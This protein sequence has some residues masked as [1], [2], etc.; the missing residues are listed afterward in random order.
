MFS[1]RP[2]RRKYRL[3]PIPYS[4]WTLN[5]ERRRK[6]G[7]HSEEI[8]YYTARVQNPHQWEDKEENQGNP[9][10]ESL[11]RNNLLHSEGTGPTPVGRQ[12]RKTINK[13][14][15]RKEGGEKTTTQRNEKAPPPEEMKI[16][17]SVQIAR[18]VTARQSSPPQPRK[19]QKESRRPKT[20]EKSSEVRRIPEVRRLQSGPRTRSPETSQSPGAKQ[21]RAKQ[22]TSQAIHKPSRPRAKQPPETHTASR[23]TQPVR[24]RKGVVVLTEPPHLPDKRQ[25]R[26][27]QNVGSGQETPRRRKRE[28]SVKLVRHDKDTFKKNSKEKGINKDKDNFKRRIQGKGHDKDTFTTPKRKESTR[29]R[30]T[31]KE[32][33]K[34]KDN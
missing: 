8:N 27:D 30:I 1:N 17:F 14:R 12:R 9:H 32:E 34:E 7:S 22:P 2:I 25:I 21:P 23:R 5:S 16:S 28:D 4:N 20:P 29:T 33:S 13:E 11:Q 3:R 31:S 18:M 6:P 15:R 26:E 19:A 24:S 10:Q